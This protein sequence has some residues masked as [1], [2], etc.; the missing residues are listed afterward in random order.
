[1]NH[2]VEEFM[3]QTVLSRGSH[4]WILLEHALKQISEAYMILIIINWI[5]NL[6][7]LIF[8]STLIGEY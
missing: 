6:L 5:D 7:K 4:L 8:I 3:T 2:N 1:M